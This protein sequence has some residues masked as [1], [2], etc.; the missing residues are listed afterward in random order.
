MNML[1]NQREKIRLEER[2]TPQLFREQFPYSEVPRIFFDNSY[3]APDLPKDIWITDT[4]FR[5]GQ[6]ARSPYTPKQIAEIFT[7]LNKLSGPNGVI[8]QSE[9]FIYSKR[10]QEAVRLCQEKGFEFPEITS[11]IRANSADLKLVKDMKMKETGILTSVSDYHIYMKLK[12][13][14]KKALS[15]YMYIVRQVVDAGIIPRCHFEDITRADIP[16]FVLPFA[17]EL[18][19]LMDESG[20]PIKIRLCDTMGYGL[21]YPSSILPRC[22]PKMVHA[23]KHEVGYPSELLEWHGHNDFHKVHVNGATSWLYGVSALN[24]SLF[25]FGERTGNP[26]LEGAVMEYIGLKGST[27]G[28]DTTVITEIAEYFTKEIKADIPGNYPFVG[29]DFNTTRAGIHVDG[30]LKNQEIY[31]I[32]DTDKLLNRP[33]KVTVT[34]KS[35][36]SGIA[37]WLNENVDLIKSG[38]RPQLTKRDRG[39]Q[40]INQWVQKQYA[41]G[42]TTSIS[43]DE[44]L[45]QARHFIPSLFISDFEAIQ[46][47]VEKR[48]LALA[49]EITAS[50]AVVD[51]EPDTMEPYLSKIVGRE[52]SIQLLAITNLDGY[53]IS[54]VHTRR[55][56]K[57]K[58]RNLMNK[59]FLEHKWFVRVK[60]TG[61]PYCSELFKSAFTDELTITTA[62]PLIGVDGKIR[63]IIDIDYKFQELAKS[64]SNIPDEILALETGDE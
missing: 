56:E 50:K 43:A 9:F 21:S 63:A 10:D 40:P 13:N 35:G 28:M 52:P 30:I 45:A 4:T 2:K 64:C 46:E 15:D 44:L 51:L 25:G 27:N 54:Q 22:I 42:R 38:E 18:K 24:T 37:R 6:Q 53:R 7:L 49:K 48:A 41:N 39:V 20:V 59:N 11:W 55:G 5:D 3:I 58:F 57:G 60:E 12:K 32:F 16:G 31:N 23:F 36:V 61:E 1:A 33:L 8:R 26:P 19:E 34:D 17:A 47:Q 14:R 62:L 29:K